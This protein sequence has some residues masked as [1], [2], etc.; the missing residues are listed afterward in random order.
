M[1]E[2]TNQLQFN[3]HPSKKYM[4]LKVPKD[5]ENLLENSSVIKY[6]PQTKEFTLSYKYNKQYDNTRVVNEF[7]Y[8]LNGKQINTRNNVFV[9]EKNSNNILPI[10]ALID[11][12]R[13]H[14]SN[15]KIKLLEKT[16]ERDM[17]F[18]N[19]DLKDSSS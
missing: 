7:V 1:K 5:T 4:L 14:D 8:S 6:N 9:L 2:D 12:Q 11:V 18:I 10:D 17:T 15:N 3:A 19:L 13:K 16:K